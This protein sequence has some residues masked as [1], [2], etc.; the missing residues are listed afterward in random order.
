MSEDVDKKPKDQLDEAFESGNGSKVAR[1]A[2]S[3][4]G[5]LIPLAG[6]A[7]GGAAGAWS[8]SESEK[9]KTYFMLGLKCKKKKSKKLVKLYTR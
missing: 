7:I 2:L 5:G 3:V 6:G 4:L 9:F 1:F 8:E